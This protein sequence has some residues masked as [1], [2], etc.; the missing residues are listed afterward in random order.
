MPITG[1]IQPTELRRSLVDIPNL[2]DIATLDDG[3]LRRIIERKTGIVL[4]AAG[5]TSLPDD[6]T[7]ARMKIDDAVHRLAFNEVRRMLR[8]EDPDVLRELNAEDR[9]TIESLEAVKEQHP[10]RGR[11]SEWGGGIVG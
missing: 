10:A 2:A 7:V 9:G 6:T 3:D 1:A 4:H 5:R 11:D 8:P